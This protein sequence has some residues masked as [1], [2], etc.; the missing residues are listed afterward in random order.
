MF[1]EDILDDIVEQMEVNDSNMVTEADFTDCFSVMAMA[2]LKQ[3]RDNIK[4]YKKKKDKI[5]SEN[6]ES[7][8][9]GRFEDDYE[10]ECWEDTNEITSTLKQQLWKADNQTKKMK[11][12]YSLVRQESEY[13]Q[14]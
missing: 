1:T 9:I 12:K 4:R 3:M 5:R 14:A 10:A 13:I 6:N 11:R 7:P 2:S 8:E